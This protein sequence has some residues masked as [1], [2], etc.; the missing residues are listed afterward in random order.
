MKFKDTITSTV[1]DYLE[2]T[3]I[4]G[5]SYLGVGRH[6][7]VKLGWFGIICTCFTLAGILIQQSLEEARDN[8]VMTTVES[9]PAPKV[10]FPAVTVDSGFP[11]RFGFP[12]NVLNG[13]AFFGYSKSKG[14]SVH[15]IFEQTI[16]ELIF[17]MNESNAYDTTLTWEGT[18]RKKMR[19]LCQTSEATKESIDV[20][21][22]SLAEN[23]LFANGYHKTLLG[24]FW[25]DS[26]LTIDIDEVNFENMDN[27]TACQKWADQKVFFYYDLYSLSVASIGFGT[28]LEYLNSLAEGAISYET[29][30]TITG[31]ISE[32]FLAQQ[33]SS[34][35]LKLDATI[36]EV[37]GWVAGSPEDPLWY[38]YT[39]LMDV[40][41]IFFAVNP[42]GIGQCHNSPEYRKENAQCCE[43]FS[44]QSLNMTQLMLLMKGSLQAPTYYTQEKE[45]KEKKEIIQQLPFENILS[46]D[47]KFIMENKNARIIACNYAN[48]K[49]YFSNM[50]NCTRFHRS[51]TNKGFGITFNAANY[52]SMF[53]DISFTKLFAQTMSPKGYHGSE[54]TIEND[55]EKLYKGKDVIFPGRSG[56]GNEL[57]VVLQEKWKSEL[58]PKPFLLTVHDPLLMPDLVDASHEIRPGVITTLSIT[59]QVVRTTDDLLS[60]SVEERGCKFNFEGSSKLYRYYS[61]DG[62]RFE[63]LLEKSYLFANCTPWNFPQLEENQQTCNY[64]M[65]EP[66]EKQMRN[67]SLIQECEKECPQEC[68]KTSY[69]ASITWEPFNPD[70]ICGSRLN[71]LDTG[72]IQPNGFLKSYEKMVFHKNMSDDGQAWCK[73]DLKRFAVVRIRLASNTVTVIKRSKRVTFTGHIANLGTK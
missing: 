24:K 38:Y 16:Q 28:F 4:H 39:A 47:P 65:L 12:E 21:L 17:K 54:D 68:T 53:N 69:I 64:R 48:E 35:L 44:F 23:I 18:L 70:W 34:Q 52:W 57:I 27:D 14:K 67:L 41:N 22:V 19:Y 66:F 15:E 30:G 13:L 33:V 43:T 40:C 61:Q 26:N 49:E 73:S 59:P 36:E 11:D 6:V 2:S 45:V 7:L 3:T 55:Q 46:S 51:I 31:F 56:K 62:C 25:K 1:N 72:P 32:H 9:V 63:C 37:I 42:L 10:P 60:N 29:K 71:F 5:F 58:D 20:Q 50:K 8:P